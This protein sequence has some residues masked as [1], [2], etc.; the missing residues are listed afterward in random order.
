LPDGKFPDGTFAS[1]T[2]GRGVGVEVPPPPATERFSIEE[3]GVALF[4]FDASGFFVSWPFDLAAAPA[5]WGPSLGFDSSRTKRAKMTTIKINKATRA[6]F[7]PLPMVPS[8]FS[9]SHR[10]TKP[11]RRWRPFRLLWKSHPST[12]LTF[13]ND[14]TLPDTKVNA[15]GI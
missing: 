3:P 13:P 5:S 9:S 1:D 11:R 14:A 12:R 2:A 6:T 4:V 10:E 15:E 8:V 7:V